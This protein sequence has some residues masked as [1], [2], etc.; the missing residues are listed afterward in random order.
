MCER[1]TYFFGLGV[2]LRNRTGIK[3]PGLA[4][5][6]RLL[7][8]LNLFRNGKGSVTDF[9]RVRKYITG[10]MYLEHLWPI[11]NYIHSWHCGVIIL[12]LIF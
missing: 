2:G 10:F 12:I 3:Y 7:V 11:L 4:L 6:K 1:N 9:T 5:I 8:T